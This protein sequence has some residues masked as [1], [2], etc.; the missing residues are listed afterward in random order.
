M[1]ASLAVTSGLDESLFRALNLAGTNE[2]LDVIMIA[3]TSLALPYVLALLAI[4]LWWKG[5]RELALDL[6]VL[7]AVVIV[8][9]EVVKYAVGRPRP[10]DVLSGANT[11]PW[12]SCASE[13]DPSFPSGHASRIF[14]VAMLLALRFKWPVKVSAFAVAI[15]AGVSRIY[16]GVHWPSDVL[17]GAV[18]GMALAAA[19]VV[20]AQR[21]AFYRSLRTKVVNGLARLLGSDA[22]A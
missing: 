15:V 21:W 11:L 6:L 9:K 8:I 18:L 14:A 22:K 19:F 17:G 1:L 7:L 3:F 4:P 16:L 10:C 5:H 13:A 12:D 20:V 2:V